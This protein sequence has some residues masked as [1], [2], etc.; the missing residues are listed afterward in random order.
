MYELTTDAIVL[1]KEESG[2]YDAVVYL[3]T[4]DLGKIRAKA[5]SLR[6]ITSKLASHVEPGWL[7]TVRLAGRDPLGNGT[8][9]QLTDG[10][11]QRK[12]Y[13]D[14]DYLSSVR[15]LTIDWHRD[16][17]FWDYL[18]E[19]RTSRRSLLGFLGFGGENQ[20]CGLCA[21][22]EAKFFEPADQIF[23]C[24]FCGLRNTKNLLTLI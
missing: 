11:S 21:E 2:D 8:P 9:F 10:L 19:G 6:K 5:K 17:G 12:V 1:D 18:L 3:Y 15:V 16:E 13:T 7:T 22:R 4:K 20:H 23:L 24:E 14:Y